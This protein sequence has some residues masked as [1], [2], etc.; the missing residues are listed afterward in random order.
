[1]I[2]MLARNWGLIVLRGVAGL[3]FAALILSNSTLTLTILVL[4]FG[5]Y[6]SADGSLMAIAAVANRAD[7]PKWPSLLITGLLSMAIG[8][9]TLFA[10]GM[11]ARTLIYLIAL[12]A[13]LV[14]VGE[15]VT[16]VRLRRVIAGEWVLLA[17][18]AVSVLF[19]IAL[20]LLPGPGALART[21]WIGV[22]AAV[23]GAVRI[24]AGLRLRPWL[25]EHDDP[26]LA[27]A[28]P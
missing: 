8:I 10:S 15:V 17:A 27:A 14:G 2:T 5:A 12:W 7:E 9:F 26:A 18:G 1:M 3:L 11:T 25:R 6:A 28:T 21:P 22:A 4:F 20:A 19:G 23:L 24:L 16:A 13:V